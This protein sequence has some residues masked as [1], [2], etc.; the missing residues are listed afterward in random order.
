M[1]GLPKKIQ[2][3]VNS[4]KIVTISKTEITY[5]NWNGVGYIVMDPETGAAGYLI[6]GGMAG[7][8]LLL[9]E[10][11]MWFLLIS[12]ICPPLGFQLMLSGFL[13]IWTQVWMLIFDYVGKVDKNTQ[14]FIRIEAFLIKIL[15]A[16]WEYSSLRFAIVLGLTIEIIYEIISHILDWYIEK[17]EEEKSHSLFNRF[18][19]R[20][21]LC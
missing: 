9:G 8:T 14:E 13:L 11:G 19:R 3:A 18:N 16:A 20:K 5:A 10:L 17:G 12:L 7:G 21:L 1:K 15:V 2:N 4:G 6:S